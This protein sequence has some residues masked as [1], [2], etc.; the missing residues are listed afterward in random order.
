MQPPVDE[1]AWPLVAVQ[2]RGAISD[3]TLGTFLSQMDGW[4]A[5]GERFGLL[6]DSREAQGLSPEQRSRLIAHMKKQSGLTARFLVQAIVLDSLLQRTLFYGIN[7]IF[8][9]PFPSK[10]FGDVAA[11]RAWL[12]EVLGDARTG[13]D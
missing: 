8:P 13:T 4:L 9:N 11:A 12:L 6:I 1:T 3:A 10:V 2:W 5:R 7:L